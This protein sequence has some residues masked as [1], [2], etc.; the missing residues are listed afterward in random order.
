MQFLCLCPNRYV[1]VSMDQTKYDQSSLKVIYKCYYS[2]P[3]VIS[4]YANLSGVSTI[5]M[6]SWIPLLTSV[7]I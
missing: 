2:L 4:H 5:Y 3:E 1:T 6:N 7:K